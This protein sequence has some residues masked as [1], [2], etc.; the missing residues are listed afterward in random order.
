MMEAQAK[1]AAQA[2]GASWLPG[3]ALR[4]AL[5]L[6][7][8]VL[9]AYLLVATWVRGG[10]GSLPE[11]IAQASARSLVDVVLF[12][13][14]AGVSYGVLAVLP[15]PSRARLW[16]FR[17]VAGAGALLLAAQL[18]FHRET[19]MFFSGDVA[20]YAL[21]NIG[22]LSKVLSGSASNLASLLIVALFAAAF[23]LPLLLRDRAAW[24]GAMLPLLMVPLLVVV[25][26]AGALNREGEGRVLA[27]HSAFVALLRPPYPEAAGG[28]IPAYAA[29]EVPPLPAAGSD[30][31][32]IVLV[33][34]ES[35]RAISVPPF[36]SGS[37]PRANMPHL[38]ALAARSRVFTRAYTTT[39]HTSKALT[40]ILCGI[41]PYPEM[42][43]VE[44]RE[45]GIPAPCLPGLL[46]QAGYRTLFI[47]SATG[48]FEN[49][50]G[51]VAN[52][53]FEAGLY[54]EQ[55][56]EGYAGSGYFGLD[57]GAIPPQFTRWWSAHPRTPKFATILTSMTHHPYQELGKAAAADDAGQRQAYLNVLEYTD[58][59]LQRI[60]DAI[61]ASG[62]AGNTVLVVTGDHGES[63]GEH[64]PRQHDSV[65]FEEVTR[66]PLLVRDG[67]DRL[68]TGTDDAL[69][70][71]L[72]L[73][74]TLVGIAG[75]R[76]EG[77]PGRDLF[78]AA[79]HAQVVTSC[80]YAGAC[81]ATLTPTLKWVYAPSQR[82]LLAFDLAADPDEASDV[83]GRYSPAE[84]QEVAMAML[85]HQESIRRFFDGRAASGAAQATR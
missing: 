6:A 51:L 64:G 63:F 38:Q 53:G 60:I 36:D 39:S 69:R 2:Q 56:A 71:H 66:V 25:A 45:G 68:P 10:D 26:Q 81:M 37:G 32:N 82:K 18:L 54:K 7:G 77:G 50:P 11:R 20:A 12:L 40:G 31:P 55:I 58:Q 46:G 17:A 67:R 14:G 72:D 43:I 78:D 30:A 16:A 21:S 3:P 23:A 41:H 42:R 4:E 15:V 24:A 1:P 22:E 84:R 28:E 34:L 76:V 48:K 35:T 75:G 65:P 73:L 52:A 61:E 8:S 47:Q 85:R 57:E 62:E 70:Q 5:G 19:G 83:S 13:L 27:G 59:V 44:S 33:V 80:W 49:R 74:P 29:P 9:T 79:G